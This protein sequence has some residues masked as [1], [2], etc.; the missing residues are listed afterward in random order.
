MDGPT[1][2]S[3]VG[4]DDG[5]F[6]GCLL[7]GRITTIRS[8]GKEA[9]LHLSAQKADFPFPT[10]RQMDVPLGRRRQIVLWTGTLII[11]CVLSANAPRLLSSFC[12]EPPIVHVHKHT[13][14]REWVSNRCTVL[15]SGAQWE[16][17]HHSALVQTGAART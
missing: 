13:M 7:N 15:Y 17:S 14:E 4:F 5:R 11:C 6:D 8:C 3:L 1:F 16:W 2:R 12:K 9:I 10:M